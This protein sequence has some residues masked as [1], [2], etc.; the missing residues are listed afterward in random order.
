MGTSVDH[1]SD[2]AA[3][4]V[5][6]RHSRADRTAAFP[7]PGT[8]CQTVRLLWI[9]GPSAVP[10]IPSGTFRRRHRAEHVTE[11]LKR[12]IDSDRVH[13]PTCSRVPGVAQDLQR[14]HPGGR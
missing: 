2:S 7:R 9:S 8:T 4:N 6:S 11:P 3:R 12:A 10:Q 13:P 1:R 5:V 14:A